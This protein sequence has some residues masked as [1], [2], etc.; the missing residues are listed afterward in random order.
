MKSVKVLD[1]TLRDGGCVNNFN[2]GQDYMDKILSSLEKSDVDIIELGYIDSINGTEMGRTQYC[3]EKVITK[4]FLKSKK[5][6]TSYVAM[7]D[8]GKFNVDNLEPRTEKSI[9]GIRL[10]FHK[11]DRMNMIDIGRKIIDKGYDFYI[12][13]MLTMRYTDKEIIELIEVVNEKLFDATAFYI[14]DSFGEMRSNDMTRVLNLIDNNLTANMPIGFHSHNNLQ[15]S[16]SN[17]MA[18]LQFQTKRDFILDVS[19]MGMGKGAGNL[20]TELLLEHLNIYYQKD[21]K[22]APLLKVIDEVINQIHKEYYWGYSVEY[23]L[24]SINRCTP[25]YA[26]HFYNKHMLS[27]EQVA[28]L[29]SMIDENK[30]VSFDKEYAEEIYRRYNMSKLYDDTEVIESL[31]TVFKDKKILVIAPGKS[32]IEYSKDI[33]DIIQNEELITINL[34]NFSIDSDYIFTTRLDAY[35]RAIKEGK[36]IIV[37]SNIYNKEAINQNIIDYSKW[38]VVED[39]TRDSSGVVVLKLL[40]SLEVKEILLA[41]FDGFS[42][43]INSNYYDKSLRHPVTE[44]EAISRNKFFKEYILEMKKEL[45]IRFLTKSLYE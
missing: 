42:V 3:N 24:S 13:P 37:P 30:K 39:G 40:K 44:E 32:I 16:Y 22:V 10:A 2:F 41:G 5:E 6:G 35:E 1:V 34:N 38:I 4:H 19:I 33:E 14:V 29:L 28:E 21:Y 31:K 9:D 25:S 17:A 15:L 12:Q 23:Y 36:N 27:I 11:K 20:N 45:D 18:L 7:M 8:Y 43:D 26:A